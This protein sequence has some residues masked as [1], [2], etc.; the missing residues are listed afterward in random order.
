MTDVAEFIG[1]SR[2]SLVPNED[3][4]TSKLLKC[5]FF[6][7]LSENLDKK[8]HVGN[9][10]LPNAGGVKPLTQS[11]IQGIIGNI[12]FANERGYWNEVEHLRYVIDEL[13]RSFAHI[14]ESKEGKF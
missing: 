13:G 3:N 9:D 5:D 11:F 7:E 6:L 4:K 12:H 1:I 2:I 10:D 14:K 8:A